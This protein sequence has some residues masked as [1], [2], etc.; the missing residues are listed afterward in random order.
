MPCGPV[1]V[2]SAGS[3][4]TRVPGFSLRCV[5]GPKSTTSQQNSWPNTTSR[6]RSIGLRPGKYRLI[7]TMRWACLR[8]CKSEPQ[9]PQASVFTSACPAAGSGAGMVSTTI[10]P[11]LKMAARMRLPLVL[12]HRDN[13]TNERIRQLSGVW[14]GLAFERQELRPSHTLAVRGVEPAGDDECGTD[15]RPGIGHFA[16]D[17][18]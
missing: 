13:G 17:Q 3:E 16:E 11:F 7:S 4:Q 9:M 18:E 2:T 1:G 12:W 6:D 14:R 8:A 5:D 15:D 10:S